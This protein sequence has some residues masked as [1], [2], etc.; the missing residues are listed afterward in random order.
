MYIKAALI[1]G[2]RRVTGI[3]D[4]PRAP[5]VVPINRRDLLLS[6]NTLENVPTKP[7]KLSRSF[8]VLGSRDCI[9]PRYRKP[10]SQ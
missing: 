2:R 3:P 6:A 9:C 1:S 8:L 7:S 4:D 5:A 10:V